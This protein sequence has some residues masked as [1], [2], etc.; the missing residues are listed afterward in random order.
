MGNLRCGIGA[1]PPDGSLTVPGDYSNPN[2]WAGA[3]YCPHV[4]TP[5]GTTT[6]EM[7]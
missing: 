5:V 4:G 1:V 3:M 2:Y 7:S 6:G